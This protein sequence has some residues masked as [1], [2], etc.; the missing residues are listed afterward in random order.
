M[1]D[2][3]TA[4]TG[5]S[6]SR[7]VLSKP[8]V[9]RRNSASA[10]WFFIPARWTMSKSHPESLKRQRAS[11]L[12]LF[13]VS[14]I[15]MR[16]PW[17]TRI[18]NRVLSRYGCK[19]KKAQTILS[20]SR[21]VLLYLR[22]ASANV[23]DKYAIGLFFLSCCACNNTHSIWTSHA[24]MQRVLC[25]VE[26]GSAR[27]GGDMSESFNEF[28]DYN[29][30]SLRGPNV[31]GW[32]LCSFAFKGATMQAKFRMK[33]RKELHSPREERSSVRLVGGCNPPIVFFV[34]DSSSKC[35][36][37]ITCPKKFNRLGEKSTLLYFAFYAW[38]SKMR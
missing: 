33:P 35:R 12:V 21:C 6:S 38:A 3:F 10:T 9:C 30:L 22:S 34:C 28:M 23:G 15:Y 11:L 25:P 32:S 20:H 36:E 29:S 13:V 37:R 4:R 14:R 2:V 17:S 27:R 7:S 8:I 16:E 26:F 31:L 24:S 19:T 5:K 1:S 18:E